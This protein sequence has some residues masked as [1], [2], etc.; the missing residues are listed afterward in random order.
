[1]S[2]S[3]FCDCLPILLI[4]HLV[5]IAL[6]FVLGVDVRECRYLNLYFNTACEQQTSTRSGR[7]VFTRKI[8]KLRNLS[9]PL[10]Q[11]DPTGL[12]FGVAISLIISAYNSRLVR[13][14]LV[15]ETKLTDRF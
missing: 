7:S 4:F 13:S 6:R 15:E 2:P 5:P 8:G 11:R 3:L 1:M 14:R 10:M 9:I 12:T